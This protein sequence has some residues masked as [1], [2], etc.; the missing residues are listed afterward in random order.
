VPD[1]TI[2]SDIKPTA[3]L[4]FSDRDGREIMRIEEDGRIYVKGRLVQTDEEVNDGLK[5]FLTSHG[6]Q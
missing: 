3:L 1:L 4:H 5:E 6:F 2:N